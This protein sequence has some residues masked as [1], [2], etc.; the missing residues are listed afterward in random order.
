MMPAARV[1]GLELTLGARRKQQKKLERILLRVYRLIS[2]KAE[3]PMRSKI[4]LVLAL[5]V[6]TLNCAA[7]E[8]QVPPLVQIRG[9][10]CTSEDALREYFEKLPEEAFSED[11]PGVL[12]ENCKWLETSMLYAVADT[13]YL[14]YSYHMLTVAKLYFWPV[15]EE[16]VYGI[17]GSQEVGPD[18]ES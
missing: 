3:C 8:D 17:I 15:S 4:L 1:I 7:A 11:N 13:S 14:V 10:I 9:V 18:E 6:S 12:G 5:L 16:E 2:E